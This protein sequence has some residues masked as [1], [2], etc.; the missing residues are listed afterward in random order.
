M[1]EQKEKTSELK[2][3]NSI[4]QRYKVAAILILFCLVS[5]YIYAIMTW[6]SESEKNSEEIIRKN[7]AIILEK[8]DKQLTNDDFAAIKIL[9]IKFSGINGVKSFGVQLSDIK[10]LEKF[11]N[12]QE[13][14]LNN[15]RVPNQKFSSIK[16]LLEHLKIVKYP[17]IE[18]L[19]LSPLKKLTKLE[20]LTLKHSPINNI[21]PLAFLINL[22]ELDISCTEILDIEP[23]CELPNLEK[24]SID[25]YSINNLKQITRFKKLKELNLNGQIAP[26]NIKYLETALPDLNI[27]IIHNESGYDL[28]LPMIRLPE[29]TK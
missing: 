7:A 13:L 1:N 17:T 23:L 15:I 8:K 27:N 29:E 10:L 5:V 21:K 25:S 22:K 9:D 11:I 4:W 2:K 26:E 24:L 28:G 12:L 14:H 3:K 20:I 18:Y 6:K 16:A 19:D